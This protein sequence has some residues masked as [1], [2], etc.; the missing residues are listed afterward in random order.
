MNTASFLSLNAVTLGSRV[1]ASAATH[2]RNAP[3]LIRSAAPSH[4]VGC[5]AAGRLAATPVNAPE[6]RSTTSVA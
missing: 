3:M 4:G 5:P 2:R 6:A 1:T